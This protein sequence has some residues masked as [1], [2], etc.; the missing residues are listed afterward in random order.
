MTTV[1][2]LWRRVL[3]EKK[4]S[5]VSVVAVLAIDVVLQLFVLYPWTV[6]SQTY[7]RERLDVIEKQEAVRRESE[8]IHK[9]VQAK[10]DAEAELDRFYRDVL[11]QGLAGARVESF[12]RLTSLAALHGLTMERRSSSPMVVERSLLRR[13]DISMLLQGEYHDLRRFIYDLEVGKEF[14]VIEEIVLRRDETVRD[15]EVL[16]LGL[17]TYYLSEGAGLE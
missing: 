9:M 13:L 12:S 6:R 1:V 3:I 14:L 5:I 4:F 15:G 17:S 10:T 11:P 7:E 8:A 2:P 16:D